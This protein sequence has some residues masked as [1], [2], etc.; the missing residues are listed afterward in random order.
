MTDV[1]K[2]L[3]VSRETIEK[4][5]QFEALVQKWT[6]H[7][8]LVSKSD[9]A[10][11]W[12]RHIIDSAQ[13]FQLSPKSSHWLDLGS[14]GGFPGI[15]AAI[16]ASELA[17]DQVFTLVDSDQRKSVFLRT[18]A[19]ELSLN[20]KVITAR[21]EA[22]PPQGSDILTARAMDDLSM[23]LEHTN[24]HLADNGVAI[25]PKGKNWEKE[26]ETAQKNWSY[27][28]ELFTSQTHPEARIL[29]IRDLERV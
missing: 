16:L 11:I 29:R 18:A 28:L 1:L 8:N 5:T 27:S 6:S 10:E 9:Q 12:D 13:I 26:H 23:L 20:V 7:I 22:L 3:G 21:A 2:E 24:R 17:P 14:G 4:L 19:R 15:V 25:F